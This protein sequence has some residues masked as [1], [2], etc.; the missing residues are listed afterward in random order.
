MI[1]L[2]VFS[3]LVAAVSVYV[4]VRRA[5]R[6]A[7]Q[8]AAD[9]PQRFHRGDVPRLGGAGI[10]LGLGAGWLLAG[11][12]P[13]DPFYLRWSAAGAVGALLCLVP[14]TFGGIVEDMTQRVRI[15][16]RLLLTFTSAGLFCLDLNLSIVRTDLA[17]VDAAIHAWPVVGVLFAVFAI[18]GLPHAFNLID[19]YNG[20][21]GTVT[22][23]TCMAISHVALQVGDRQLAA[24]VV[25]LAG[26]TAGFLAFNYPRG[27]IFAGDGG[28]YVWGMVIA[29]ACVALVQRHP[30]VSPWFPILLLVYPVSETLFSIY[31]KLARGQS[32]GT[33]DALH[34][35]QLIFRRIVRPVM[36]DNEERQLLMRNNKTAP[37]LWMVSALS[38]LPAVMLWRHTMALAVCS[39]LFVLAYVAAY[40]TIVRFKVP[41]WLRF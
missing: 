18:G 4:L 15:G 31:R 12:M 41:A 10:L 8:Y 3:F 22:V 16:L 20:L 6:H 23:L 26:A 13:G 39:A 38:V 21:A 40:L 30:Q 7:A 25:C 34:F 29:V 1:I 2:I 14:A 35:H 36:L 32:P 37:Y 27:R 11:L 33:A 9:L 24:M 19:G 17:W 28:A 5:R